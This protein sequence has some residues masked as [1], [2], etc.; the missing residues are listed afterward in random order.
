MR[1]LSFV[2]SSGLLLSLNSASLAAKAEK[3]AIQEK[4]KKKDSP[5]E[6]TNK[7]LQ[8]ELVKIS[9]KQLSLS[10]F[11][12]MLKKQTAQI[13]GQ[14]LG[15]NYLINLK[16]KKLPT[17]ITLELDQISVRAILDV[18]CTMYNLRWSNNN[19]IVIIRP[20]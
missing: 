9:A 1:I 18:I 7:L 2:F 16:G 10:D 11:M 13:K 14:T 19:G 3:P 17:K 20:R 8:K 5:T 15:L 4:E 6:W 12:K